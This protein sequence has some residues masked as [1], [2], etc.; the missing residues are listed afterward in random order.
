MQD[1]DND[2]DDDW[3]EVDEDDETPTKCLFCDVVC[4]NSHSTLKHCID[5]HG[6]NFYTVKHHYGIVN[7]VIAWLCSL[8]SSYKV[9]WLI[10]WWNDDMDG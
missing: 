6:F 3:E 2:A 5:E 7:D 4:D 9:D 1:S 10:G 8:C